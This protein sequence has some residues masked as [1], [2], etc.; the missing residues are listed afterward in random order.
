MAQAGTKGTHVALFASPGIGHLIPVLELGERFVSLFNFEVTVFVAAVTH[1]STAE[2]QLDQWSASCKNLLNVVLLPP[3]DITSPMTESMAILS[4][5]VLLVRQTLPDLRSAIASMTTRPTA[6]IVDIFGTEAF[7]IADEFH[8]LKYAFFTTNAWFLALTLYAP[9]VDRERENDHVLH[10]MPLE[11]PGCA[12]VT[13]EDTIDV[14]IDQNDTLLH[15]D[16][17]KIALELAKADGI[18]SNTW[19]DLEPKTLL[20]LRDPKALSHFF[21]VRIFP[22]GPLVRGVQSPGSSGLQLSDILQWLD[23]QP[24]E[25]VLYVS[26]GSG[27]T[28]SAD[29]MTELAWGLERSQ[30]RFIWVVRPP[31]ENNAC[32]SYFEAA[33]GA[34]G[35]PE[36]LPDGFVTRTQ[37][38]GL[39]IPMWAP[40]SEILAHQSVGGF[41]SH[42]GWNSTL[43]SI[44]NGVPMIAWPLY[45]EQTM[46]A[47][48][49]SDQL[50]VALMSRDVTSEGLL[51]RQEIEKMVRTVLDKGDA[52]GRTIRDRVQDLR[53][54]SQMV[55]AQGGSSHNAL[56]QVAKECEIGLLGLKKRARGA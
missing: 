54:S 1:S 11:I 7:A 12:S 15:D 43:E 29:Q 13:Y 24:A 16:F 23:H 26:F 38:V 47:T 48:M 56:S 51:G 2:C 37:K 33:K 36:Y 18:L 19:E 53:R 28:L 5:L 46:N 45:A 34:D 25:S 41:L 27:G 20:A 14:Y 40:Q 30:Q 32:G 22:V 55:L 6:L 3:V 52:T 49:L 31:L 9:Y 42:C 50:G 44:T 21:Q 10:H 17:V 8:M 35:T 4:Q 39:V